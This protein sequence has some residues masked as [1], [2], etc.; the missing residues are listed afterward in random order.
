MKEGNT[1]SSFHGELLLPIGFKQIDTLL[2]KYTSIIKDTSSNLSEKHTSKP[3]IIQA[4]QFL[5]LFSRFFTDF[6]GSTRNYSNYQLKY[7]KKHLNQFMLINCTGKDSEYIIDTIRHLSQCS[8]S[9]YNQYRC[10]DGLTEHS[11]PDIISQKDYSMLKDIDRID[12]N[13][14]A[15]MIAGIKSDID[16]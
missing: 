11:M 6:I 2:N 8:T 10:N 14:Y 16:E 1:L 7:Y 4:Q 9:E 5:R 12:L 15:D 13:E 3:Y